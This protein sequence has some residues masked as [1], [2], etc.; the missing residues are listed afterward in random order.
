M[1]NRFSIFFYFI[2]L[3]FWHD[4]VNPLLHVFPI[5]NNTIH[6]FLSARISDQE[7]KV[8]WGI[9]KKLN[10]KNGRVKVK[11]KNVKMKTKTKARRSRIIYP[12]SLYLLLLTSALSSCVPSLQCPLPSFASSIY[13]S[14][15]H[16]R[17]P[18]ASLLYNRAPLH[19]RR[20]PYRNR[21]ER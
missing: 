15:R 20:H 14:V 7:I 18:S 17:A 5:G 2:T 4:V 21:Y 12:L 3:L 1:E 11:N 16:Q 6:I 13:V 19:P 8:Y 9:S 10:P